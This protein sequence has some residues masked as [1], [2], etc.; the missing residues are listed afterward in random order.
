LEHV[1]KIILRALLTGAA[2]GGVALAAPGCSS[3]ASDCS[4]NQ[5]W[6]GTSGGDG[7]G[8]GD[9]VGGAG[10]GGGDGGGGGGGMI[11]CVP[12]A[13]PHDNGCLESGVFVRNEGDDNGAGTIDAPLRTLAAAVNAAQ[14]GDGIIYACAQLFAEEL[15]MPAGI[16]FYGGLDCDAGWAWTSTRTTIAPALAGA[17]PIRLVG[18]AGADPLIEDV[19]AL[20][21]EGATPGGSSIALIANDISATL[22]RMSLV[23]G[24]GQAGSAGSSMGTPAT[25]GLQGKAGN[26]ANCS[27]TPVPG[28]GTTANPSCSTSVGGAGG[29]GGNL[30]GSSG[31]PG[32]P[33]TPGGGIGGAGQ[34]SSGPWLCPTGLMNGL[35][36]VV[37]PSGVGAN[38]LGTITTM[39]YV[40]A[41]GGLGGTG[42]VGQG[43]GGGGG[44]KE[45]PGCEL[46][47]TGAG[48]AGGGSGGCGGIGGGGGSAGGASIALLSDNASLTLD[49]VLLESGTGGDGGPGGSGQP[50]GAGGPGGVAALLGC[51]GGSGGIGG[52]GGTG[53]GGRGG[54]SLGI[55]YV[56]AAPTIRDADFVT[57]NAGS[58]GPGGNAGSDG[59]AGTAQQF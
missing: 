21:P 6:N 2:L 32:A 23:A 47:G 18:S 40:G 33:S 35:N 26:A 29:S 4:D 46:T 52:T 30:T 58:G 12:G 44:A 9:A 55:A 38:A 20:A 50:G 49:Q 1:S 8:G 19:D 57:G 34:P 31:L 39:G 59:V 56:G 16:Q 41:A 13:T 11:P 45:P 10:M 43:G 24:D 28:G 5:C 14:N 36:G 42:A 15:V 17:V 53:G 7:A 27:T 48:G 3:L 25:A 54:H 22:R 37:G 51:A